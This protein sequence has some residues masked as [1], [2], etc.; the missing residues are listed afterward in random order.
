MKNVE[1]FIRDK[2]GW[3]I[4]ANE[5][6]YAVGFPENAFIS[7]SLNERKRNLDLMYEGPT[8][9]EAIQKELS[10][11]AKNTELNPQIVSSDTVQF[12]DYRDLWTFEIPDNFEVKIVYNRLL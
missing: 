2:T 6:Q 9:P 3:F 1:V 7:K 8:I 10:E 5:K 12:P 4:R 11:F